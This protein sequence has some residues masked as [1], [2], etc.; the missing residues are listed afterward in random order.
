MPDRG[1]MHLASCYQFGA[2]L[3]CFILGE[4]FVI[5]PWG[6]CEAP[7]FVI[8]RGKAC[9]PFSGR[10]QSQQRKGDG[11]RATADPPG[12]QL[13]TTAPHRVLLTW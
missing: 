1:L 3:G 7:C 10:E 6:H 4:V 2:E 8:L 11:P 9:Q 12:S 13:L 5:L